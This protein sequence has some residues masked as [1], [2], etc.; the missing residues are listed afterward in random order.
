MERILYRDNLT[1]YNHGYLRVGIVFRWNSNLNDRSMEYPSMEELMERI[2]NWAEEEN[3]DA[4]IEVLPEPKK[5][6]SIL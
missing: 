5:S 4:I 1:F 6:R 2:R 3:Y